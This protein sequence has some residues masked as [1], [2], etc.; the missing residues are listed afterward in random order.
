MSVS[1]P[2]AQPVLRVSTVHGLPDVLWDLGQNPTQVIE[3]LGFE[4]TLF[5]NPDNRITL[6]E[7]GRL[8]ECCAEVSGCPHL[9]LLVGLQDGLDQLG[10]VGLL[11]RNAPDVGT[12]LHRLIRFFHL[13]AQGVEIGLAVDGGRALFS[14]A[15]SE[16]GVPGIDQTGDGA[17][18]AQ[19]NIMRE[20][21]GPDFKA[22][23]VWFVRP[24]P[25][26]LKPYT[27]FFHMKL[28][29]DA[30]IYGVEFSPSWLTRR[31][32]TMDAALGDLI[33]EKIRALELQQA[34][35][36]ADNVRTLMQTSLA[37]NHVNAQHIASMLGMHVR[38]YH[39]RLRANGTS[40]RELLDQTRMALTFRL[41]QYSSKDIAEISELLGYAEPR[42]FIRA[43]KR[44]TDTT[45]ARWRRNQTV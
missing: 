27:D 20:L 25:K 28:K 26:I 1:I 43:F 42:S 44:W 40:H 41:L 45:P 14:Y 16:G 9:G 4:P 12:A 6:A 38:T 39:R 11:A 30:P 7:R 31:L 5:D 18:A 34:E 13:Q 22:L 23:A 32:P 35:N 37:F 29:F 2:H 36:L 8:L 21:C 19:F 3:G 33:N 15:I 10:I 24:Q 17:V